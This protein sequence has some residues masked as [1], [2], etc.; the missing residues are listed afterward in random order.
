MLKIGKKGKELNGC[1]WLKIWLSDVSATAVAFFSGGWRMQMLNGVLLE[2]V[3][4]V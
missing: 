2:C 3:M 1:H 4:D